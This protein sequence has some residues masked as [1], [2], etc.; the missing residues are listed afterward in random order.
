MKSQ[1]LLLVA[2]AITLHAP[3]KACELQN[4]VGEWE[5]GG[6]PGQCKPGHTTSRITE[7]DSKSFRW[8]DGEGSIGVASLDKNTFT[9]LWRTGAISEADLD[10]TCSRLTWAAGH[11]D[12]RR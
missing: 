4:M 2:A 11:Y 6:N 3:A 9:V 7:E 5:C 1:F 8:I 12:T 10:E